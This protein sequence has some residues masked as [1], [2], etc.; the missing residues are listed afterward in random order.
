MLILSVVF[1]AFL[2]LF[3]LIN[4]KYIWYV[5]S[6]PDNFAFAIVIVA[7]PAIPVYFVIASLN[8]R[9]ASESEVTDDYLDSI[10]NEDEDE[11]N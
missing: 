7:M 11:L 4:W 10:I 2:L 1:I 6:N 9:K 8:K 5:I 3:Y